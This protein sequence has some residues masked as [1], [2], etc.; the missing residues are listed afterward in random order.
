M[1][2]D[3]ET[4]PGV[5]RLRWGQGLLWSSAVAAVAA[6]AGSASTVADAEASTVVVELWR[7]YGLL[8]FA[9]LFTILAIA[10]RASRALWVLVI[11]NKIL[12]AVSGL[13]LLAVPGAQRYTGAVDL[14][15]WDGALCV[16]LVTAFVCCRGWVS[17]FR[18]AQ[19]VQPA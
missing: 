11:A 3:A 1:V 7:G 10:P 6:A 8:V 5:V 12:L 4:T 17:D 9:G 15:V 18:N 16:L 2:E 19:P 14:V 13:V